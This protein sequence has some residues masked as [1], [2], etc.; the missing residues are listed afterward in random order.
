MRSADAFVI[1]FSLTDSSSFE[2]VEEWKEKIKKLKDPIGDIEEPILLIGS[3]IDQRDSSDSCVKTEEVKE[4]MS[5]LGLT[6]YLELDSNDP[7][8]LKEVL[9]FFCDN[10]KR[11]IA[12]LPK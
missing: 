5:K 4:K 10:P 3:K 2:K 6:G 12:S 1:M 11:T 7:K 9:L 8:S